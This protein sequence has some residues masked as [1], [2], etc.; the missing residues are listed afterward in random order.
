MRVQK[1]MLMAWLCTGALALEA[2]AADGAVS[3]GSQA[4]LR[5]ELYVRCVDV[6]MKQ[7]TFGGGF[8][9]HEMCLRWARRQGL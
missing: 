2:C 7:A 1:V 8:A 6:Q 3:A 5:H 9:V 4:A